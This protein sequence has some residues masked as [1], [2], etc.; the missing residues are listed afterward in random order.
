M[1]PRAIP[2]PIAPEP[3]ARERKR[4]APKGRQPSAA[5][6]ALVRELFGERL[7]R[8]DLLIE[9]L[10]VLQD[11][12]GHLAADHLAAL[13]HEMRLAQTE[14][15]KVAS[16]YHHFDIVKEGEAA[17]PALTVRVCDGIAC[18]L[19]GARELLA[20]LPALLGR[21]VR[22]LP[23]P[24]I[25]R[26]EHAPA[27]LVGQHPLHR[28]SAD[29]VVAAVAGGTTSDVT[30]CDGAIDFAAYR[31]DGGYR[32]YEQCL[33]GAS[34]AESDIAA[35]EGCGLR[36]VGGAGWPAGRK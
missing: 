29:A 28:A 32:L 22:V 17:P 24:C 34:D 5:A 15:Y 6:R 20:R 10:H 35:L 16:F 13:A 36:G 11:R 7:Q 14:V 26:C 19:A 31:A 33:A 3:A 23:A 21:D 8:R 4:M 27:A 1:N 25:G 30:S 9:H 2:I 12:H 18:E